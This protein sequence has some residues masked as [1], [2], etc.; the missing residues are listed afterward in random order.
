MVKLIM[1]GEERKIWIEELMSGRLERAK[2]DAEKL[3]NL[4]GYCD[5][6]AKGKKKVLWTTPM[7]SGGY[8]STES[9]T[10]CEVVAQNETIIALM[11]RERKKL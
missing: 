2:F 6:E 5:P 4:I 9:Q 7:L 3:R 10:L 8:F 1:D 11:L